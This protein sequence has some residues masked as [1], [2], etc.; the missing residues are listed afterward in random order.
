MFGQ[1]S[2]PVVTTEQVETLISAPS[3]TNA[4]M[5]FNSTTNTLGLKLNNGTVLIAKGGEPGEPITFSA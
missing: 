5:F 2:I 3:P 4:V 1:E